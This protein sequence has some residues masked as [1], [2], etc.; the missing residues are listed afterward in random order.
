MFVDDVVELVLPPFPLL[1]ESNTAV[2]GTSVVTESA[3]AANGS[4]SAAAAPAAMSKGRL[5][6]SNFC[7]ANRTESALN[8]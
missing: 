6:W 8:R 2:P 4:A 3:E 5:P 1:C 7:H